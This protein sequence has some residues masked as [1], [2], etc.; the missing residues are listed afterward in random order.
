MPLRVIGHTDRLARYQTE[1][2]REKGRSSRLREEETPDKDKKNKSERL[3]ERREKRK[4]NLAKS[5]KSDWKQKWEIKWDAYLKE[6]RDNCINFS[7]PLGPLWT[8]AEWKLL[9]LQVRVEMHRW[10]SCSVC[11]ICTIPW[12]L[13]TAAVDA[14]GDLVKKVWTSTPES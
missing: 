4:E 3:A 14:A 12:Y 1:D 13:K 2:Q 5:D 10:H 6:R 9:F 11:A 8:Q 7:L